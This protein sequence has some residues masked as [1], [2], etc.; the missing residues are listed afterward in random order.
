[1]A[2][3]VAARGIHVDSV[4]HVV[5]FDLPQTPDDFIHR[6]GRTGRAGQRGSAST[7]ISKSERGEISRIERECKVRLLRREL[8][9]TLLSG[10]AEPPQPHSPSASSESPLSAPV[11]TSKKS[12]KSPH[13]RFA[14]LHRPMVN[15]Q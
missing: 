14:S 11:G 1:M 2:T 4:A 8:S 3:D 15:F 13:Q 7:F 9:P 5:N 6:V 12:P 10:F